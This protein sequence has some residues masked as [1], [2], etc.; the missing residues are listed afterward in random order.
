MEV[1]DKLWQE[2]S[3]VDFSNI[4]LLQI[5]GYL[6]IALAETQTLNISSRP[7]MIRA[8]SKIIE[9]L[10]GIELLSDQDIELLKN[11]ENI[12]AIYHT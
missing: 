2:L 4:E 8:L 11:Q 10:K 1:S 6:C 12:F 9:H 5:H 7:S 3:L